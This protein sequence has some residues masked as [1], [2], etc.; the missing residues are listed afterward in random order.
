MLT[1]CSFEAH[2]DPEATESIAHGR[3]SGS[4][5]HLVYNGAA[6]AVP[7]RDPETLVDA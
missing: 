7:E 5:A 2:R 6:K 3:S 4:G 1:G